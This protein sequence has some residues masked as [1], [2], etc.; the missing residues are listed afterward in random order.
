MNQ[1]VSFPTIPGGRVEVH[2]LPLFQ[3]PERIRVQSTSATPR[4]AV[5]GRITRRACDDCQGFERVI[6]LAGPV[7]CANP[8]HAEPAPKP[9]LPMRP[10]P[11][12][13]DGRQEPPTQPAS[14]RTCLLAG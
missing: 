2:D 7:T 9:S 3:S 6:T 13:R 11:H 12:E 14:P 10:T 5:I 4:L 1:S 8:V